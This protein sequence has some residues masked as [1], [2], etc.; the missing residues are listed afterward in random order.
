MI[1][2]RAVHERTERVRDHHRPVGLLIVL[3]NG[4]E[5]AADRQPGAV[6]RVDELRFAG[7]FEAGT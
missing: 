5:R 1:T 3:E 6:E 7:S 2:D 4:D